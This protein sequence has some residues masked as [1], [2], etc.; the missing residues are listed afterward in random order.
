LTLFLVGA[1]VEFY[2]PRWRTLGSLLQEGVHGKLVIDQPAPGCGKF[3]L[4]EEA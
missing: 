2:E 4:V 1:A 3:V